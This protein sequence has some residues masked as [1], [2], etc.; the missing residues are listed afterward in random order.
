MRILYIS[1]LFSG[2]ETSLSAGRWSPAGV[3][4]IYKVIEMLA[5]RTGALRIVFA[6]KPGHG[7]WDLRHDVE[8]SMA[9]LSAS[10]RVLAGAARFGH[11]PGKFGRVL[12]EIRQVFHIFLEVWRYKP[13][14]IYI[15]HGNVWAA[16]V[17]A[18]WCRAPLLFRVMGVYPAM[19]RALQ[20]PR[21]VDA[22]LRWCYRAPYATVICTQDGS[23]V[24]SWLSDAL[25]PGV[26]TH[27]LVN[28]VELPSPTMPHD[29]VPFAKP[30][31][32][33]VVGFVGKLEWT[34]G[35]NEFL[36][37]FLEA[38]RQDPALHA[39]LV[40][41]GS[42]RDQLSA[43]ANAAGAADHVTFL[44]R[45]PHDQVLLVLQQMDIYVSM[46]R[47]G[48]LSAANLE[49]MRIGLCM[50]FPRSRPGDGVDVV[51]DRL[52]P[53]DTAVRISDADD[54][55]GLGEAILRLHRMPEERSC[56]AAATAAA[57]GKFIPTWSERLQAE[58]R[59]LEGLRQPGMAG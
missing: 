39:V 36:A 34:K 59:I 1:R 47:F 28:G 3:P 20:S 29:P 31:G 56:R 41:Q 11:A 32:R 14:L 55:H 22:V 6:R 5:S 18:R 19:R 58:L 37:G 12:S 33:T 35:C 30:A 54:I 17:L 24:E 57:A 43:A 23:G 53:A 46:N 8:V 25:A 15:D 21:L 52:M 4:T 48:N 7:R 2:L 10:C 13:D 27:V 16:G 49:A 9:G 38:W 50:I 45:L 44:S 42:C 26:P 40:G 51:T